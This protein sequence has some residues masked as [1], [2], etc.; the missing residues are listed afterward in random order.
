MSDAE[1]STRVKE[2]HKFDYMDF[3]ALTGQFD[4]FGYDEI[5]RLN[6]ELQE[7]TRNEG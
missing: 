7:G 1:R 2:W 3:I 5:A 4:V 6:A